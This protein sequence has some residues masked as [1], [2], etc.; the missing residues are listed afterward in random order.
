VI[1]LDEGVNIPL[2]GQDVVKLI[3]KALSVK[4]KHLKMSRKFIFFWIRI[5]KGFRI[6]LDAAL[7]P[8]MTTAFRSLPG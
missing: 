7:V 5:S 1:F 8:M 3:L 4:M 6:L 2:I